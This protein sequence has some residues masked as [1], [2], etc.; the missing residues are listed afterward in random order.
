MHINITRASSL[1]AILAAIVCTLG[2]G[3]TSSDVS[4]PPDSGSVDVADAGPSRAL[5]PEGP[6]MIRQVLAVEAVV[7]PSEDGP[8][9]TGQLGRLAFG[10]HSHEYF[11]DDDGTVPNA[12]PKIG[13]EIR[14]VLDEQIPSY[15]LEDIE[16]FDGSRSRI[17]PDTTPSELAACA[18]SNPPLSQCSTICMVGGRSVGFYDNN[19]DGLPDN[20]RLYDHNPSPNITEYGVELICDE[21]SVPLDG[22]FS[23]LSNA[24][25]QVFDED[26]GHR[27]LG[28]AIVL[29]PEDAL[30]L[31]TN[32]DCHI[33]FRPDVVDHDGNRICAPPGGLITETCSDGDVSLVRFHTDTLTM[34][35]S[36]PADGE[37]DVPLYTSQFFAMA[38]NAAINTDT[39]GAVT[40][41]NGVSS[42]PAN[43]EVWDDPYLLILSLDEDFAP[44][45]T[46]TLTVSTA[47]QDVLGGSLPTE[48]TVTWTTASE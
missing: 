45:T 43:V 14:I 3:E 38:F 37:V 47:L 15:A 40:V 5:N 33:Q 18:D 29:F 21:V 42:I 23:H 17:P 41:S 36:V 22:R 28:P 12:F 44:S 4:S 10:E 6:P 35:R 31:P 20:R 2:C 34:L 24:G 9:Y 32:A 26:L 46:Y 7:V 13:Q 39:L 19:D 30:G 11:A 48:V 27:S 1:R 16:C 8:R 25:S